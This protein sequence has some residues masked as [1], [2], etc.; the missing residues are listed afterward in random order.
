MIDYRTPRNLPTPSGPKENVQQAAASA[1]RAQIYGTGVAVTEKKRGGKRRDRGE[2][3]RC[4]TH[5]RLA[6]I[7]R[8]QQ[9]VVQFN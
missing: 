2:Y 7:N 3:N 8:L 1:R 6:V 5:Y 9:G 4:A